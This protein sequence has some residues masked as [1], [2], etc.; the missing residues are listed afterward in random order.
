M[1]LF[2]LLL[3][4]VFDDLFIVLFEVVQLFDVLFCV[5]KLPLLGSAVLF[6]LILVLVLLLIKLVFLTCCLVR[7]LV[8]A[9]TVCFLGTKRTFGIRRR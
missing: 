6:V 9:R 1:L 3:L 8:I 7:K 5:I 4:V 2:I